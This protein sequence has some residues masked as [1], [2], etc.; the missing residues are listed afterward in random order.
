MLQLWYMSWQ[1]LGHLYQCVFALDSGTSCECCP[2]D[3]Q[4]V[5]I[6]Q[7]LVFCHILTR[8]TFGILCSWEISVLN[9]EKANSWWNCAGEF[10]SHCACSVIMLSCLLLSAA[11]PFH[12]GWLQPLPVHAPRPHQVGHEPSPIWPHCWSK[13]THQWDCAGDLGLWGEAAFPWSHRWSGWPGK[14]RQI[15]YVSR[16]LWLVSQHLWWSWL[17]VFQFVWNVWLSW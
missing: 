17:W 4:I 11:C 9:E 8:A 15:A 7:L 16:A 3:I 6:M 1:I 2:S 12:S 13:G 14:V 5:M 10:S